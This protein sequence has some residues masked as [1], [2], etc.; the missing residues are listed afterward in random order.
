MRQFM[1][2]QFIDVETKIIG[3]I[4][5]RQF[6]LMVIMALIDFICYKIFTFT[7]FIFLA[8]LN[9]AFWGTMAFLRINGQPFHYFLLNLLQTLKKPRLRIWKKEYLEIKEEVKIKPPPP[10]P[11][12]VP[13]TASRLAELSL[14]VDT[15]GVY[16]G[17]K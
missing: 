5:V 8:V 15:G 4:T 11:Q 10:P 9:L 3:P 13:L 17:E 16:K 14:I 6:I 7:F 1:V 2:P 12:K